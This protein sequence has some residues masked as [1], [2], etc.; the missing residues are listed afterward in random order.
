M[1]T[2]QSSLC[3]VAI[4]IC[5]LCAFL[6]NADQSK[7]RKRSR[8]LVAYLVLEALWFAMEWLMQHPTSPAKALWLGS[9]MGLS[10]F[11]APCLWLF[12]RQITE[13]QTPSIRSLPAAHFIVVAIGIALTLPLIQTTHLGPDYADPNHVP[14][15]LHNLFIHGTMLACIAL[16]L[17]QV[18]YYMTECVRIL[19]RHA[20]HTKALFSNIEHKT[21]N[22]LRILIFVVV[23]KWFVGLLRALY[24]ITL[25]RD[26]GW[27]LLFT[28]M[29]VG[30]TVWALFFVMRQS[31]VFSVAERKLVDDL[32]GSDAEPSAGAEARYARSS[33]DQPTRA[34]IR[35]KLQDAMNTSHGYRDNRLTLRSLCQQIKENPHYVSQVI[36][37][38]LGASFYDLV[39]VHRV[40]NA[41]RLLVMAPEKTVIDIALEVGFNSKSTFNAAFRHHTGSTPTAYRNSQL[42]APE[43]G[44]PPDSGK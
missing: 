20:A 26:T 33:L 41:K 4:A 38:D 16:F 18:P 3:S 30:V 31:T 29:E 12:A 11:V 44:F 9:L 42:S 22:T 7:P 8:Y 34:R 37:Q 14:T 43:P 2:L 28:G 17:V 6:A 39:N 5:V 25:G 15:K 35:R 1:S 36:N 32:F 27:G 10:L 23:T 13:D 21:L 40:E 24:C 19:A